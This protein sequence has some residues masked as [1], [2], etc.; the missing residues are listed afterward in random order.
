MLISKKCKRQLGLG[1]QLNFPIIPTPSEVALKKAY[2]KGIRLICRALAA[3]NDTS[4]FV[5]EAFNPVMGDRS[6]DVL[7]C[8]HGQFG[9]IGNGGV[10]LLHCS[11]L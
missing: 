3:G 4:F 9:E 6:M 11:I 1:P 7:A 2:P 5:V 10:S 8:G